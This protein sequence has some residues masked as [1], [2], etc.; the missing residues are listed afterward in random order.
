MSTNPTS[1]PALPSSP[2]ALRPDRGSPPLRSRRSRT[3]SQTVSTAA[4]GD[5]F[6]TQQ[7]AGRC[8]SRIATIHTFKLFRCS[9]LLKPPPPP[10][11]PGQPRRTSAF[12]F[13]KVALPGLLSLYG[14]HRRREAASIAAVFDAGQ[15]DSASEQELYRP[16]PGLR[17]EGLAQYQTLK[18]TLGRTHIKFAGFLTGYLF[19]TAS[20]D[21]RTTPISSTLQGRHVRQTD[22]CSI[23]GRQSLNQAYCCCD[24]MLTPLLAMGDIPGSDPVQM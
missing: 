8:S 17:E 13:R 12:R 4:R 11:A 21:V 7:S 10:R 14:R 9:K 15:P 2:A 22:E 5:E 24:C 18:E 19:L 23:S 1:R 3:T 16:R 20:S 6:A